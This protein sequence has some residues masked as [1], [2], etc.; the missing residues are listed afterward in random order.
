M[1]TPNRTKFREVP[2][3][4]GQ[5]CNCRRGQERDNC[6]ACEGTGRRIDFAAIRARS[7]ARVENWNCDGSGPHAA[8][9]VRSLP[10]GGDSN[11]ILCRRCYEREM[12]WRR[13]RNRELSADVR[14]S[15]PS[16]DSLK[17]YPQP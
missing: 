14:F 6:P 7:A 10:T 16:W 5:P 3:L 13:A 4:Y 9:E 1:I 2:S 12:I 17:T 15:L 8:G 11:A